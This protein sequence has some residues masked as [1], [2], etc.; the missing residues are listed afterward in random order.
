M[1]TRFGMG[2]DDGEQAV[3]TA[4]SRLHGADLLTLARELPG[5]VALIASLHPEVRSELVRQTIADALGVSGR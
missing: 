2:S 5:A 1:G 3:A 4:V